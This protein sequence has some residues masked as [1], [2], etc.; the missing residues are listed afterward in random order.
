M[1]V[2]SIG[3]A[4]RKTLD[5]WKRVAAL[6]NKA[7]E[8]SRARKIQFAC[9]NHDFEFTPIEGTIGYDVLLAETD[10]PGP[11]RNGSVLDYQGRE[12]S[13]RLFREV[14]AASRCST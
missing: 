3:P 8:A 6:F 11:A 13:A 2:A 14:P 12:G 9:H 4:E 5:D 7:G 10:H 1:V